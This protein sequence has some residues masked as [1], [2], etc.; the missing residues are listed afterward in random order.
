MGR[1]K[2]QI[3]SS[4]GRL[5]FEDV[6]LFLLFDLERSLDGLYFVDVMKKDNV[7]A[8]SKINTCTRCL[9]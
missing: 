8:H 5:C 2:M 4:G 1:I 9:L 7:F 6:F 3:L